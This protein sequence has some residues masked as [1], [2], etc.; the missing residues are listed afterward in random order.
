MLLL[1]KVPLSWE[2]FLPTKSFM[3]RAIVKGYLKLG[4]ICRHWKVFCICVFIYVIHKNM[5]TI[6]VLPLEL[7]S[8]KKHKSKKNYL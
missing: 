1:A 8:W 4:C 5:K 2:P 7:Y 6:H 3:E